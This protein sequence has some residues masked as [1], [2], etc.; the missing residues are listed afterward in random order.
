MTNKPLMR[1]IALLLLGPVLSGCIFF[2]SRES[3]A[4]R[5]D[6]SFQAGY[7]DGCAS[8]NARGA[9]LRTGGVVRD[10]ALYK[11]SQPYRAGWG[12]GYATCNNQ[13]PQHGPDPNMGG[14]QPSKPPG[15]L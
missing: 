3:R 4:M 13:V 14:M 6:P 7:A 1:A 9:N 2:E 10:E 12:N 11:A 15:T 5:R 8:A